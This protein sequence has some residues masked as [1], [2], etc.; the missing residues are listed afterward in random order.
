MTRL[1]DKPYIVLLRLFLQEGLDP[2]AI[3][4]VCN[5][6]RATF[7]VCRLLPNQS[8]SISEVKN[9]SEMAIKTIV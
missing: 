9:S 2:A 6:T 3:L 7:A 5:P 8:L 1:A 4:K